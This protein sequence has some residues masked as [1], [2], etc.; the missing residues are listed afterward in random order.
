MGNLNEE[1]IRIL[2]RIL[3]M[4]PESDLGATC[5]ETATALANRIEK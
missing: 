2:V 3:R 5:G 1:E 4:V